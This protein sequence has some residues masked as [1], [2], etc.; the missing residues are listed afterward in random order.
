ML[1]N[2]L[3]PPI[4]PGIKPPKLPVM[5]SVRNESWE[6]MTSHFEYSKIIW[7]LK[8]NRFHYAIKLVFIGPNG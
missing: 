3:P 5:P 8:K 4:P 6:I 7:I 2:G 1:P